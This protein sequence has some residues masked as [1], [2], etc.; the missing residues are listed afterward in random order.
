MLDILLFWSI[1]I[2]LLA[3]VGVGLLANDKINES[4][5]NYLVAGRRLSLPLAATT[6]MAQSADANATLGNANL[7]SEFGFWAGASLPLGLALCL[8]I[9]GLFFAKPLNRMGLLTLPDFYRLR[10]NRTTEVAASVIMVLSFSFLLA[11]NLVAGGYIFQTFLKTSYAIGVVTIAIIVLVYTIGGGLLAVAYTDVVQVTIALLGALSLFAFVFLNF[12]FTVPDGMGPLALEQ[13]TDPAA[14]AFVNW[15]ALLALGLGDIV[16][17]DFMARVFA[18]ESPE[19]SQKACFIG[20]LGTVVIGIP[21]TLVTL[22]TPAILQPLNVQADGSTLF[23]LLESVAP[24]A[25]SLIVVM[26]ILAASFSTADGAVLGTASVIAHNIVGVSHIEE[27][28]GGNRLLAATR[29]MA[30]VVMML[31]VFLALRVPQNGLLLLLAFDLGFAGLLVPLAGGLFWPKAT[32]AGALACIVAG[33][34]TRL[35]LFVLT[36]T[37]FG[38]DN[39]LLYLPNNFLGADFDGLPTLLSPL[40]GFVVFVTV[41]LLTHQDERRVQPF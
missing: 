2:F 5:V 25:I 3:N 40:L 34:L 27:T 7:T 11:G 31:A 30:F 12:G 9:T 4:S 19:T 41:S 8:L 10:Y 18:A 1:L 39:N 14:G 15:A 26:G 13:L 36:P 6:L 24:A 35:V 38:I 29:T 33:S 20:A 28:G 17:I 37:A 32:A 23:T 21:Y 22:A 16:A